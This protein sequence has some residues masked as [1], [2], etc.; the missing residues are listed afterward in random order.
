MTI[1]LGRAQNSDYAAMGP[2]CCPSTLVPQAI[3]Q[4]GVARCRRTSWS[5]KDLP[6]WFWMRPQR[7]RSP[8]Q[9]CRRPWWP[10]LS[11]WAIMHPS[12]QP[13]QHHASTPQWP[14][15]PPHTKVCVPLRPQPLMTL[16]QGFPC[17]LVAISTWLNLTLLKPC[18]A[19]ACTFVW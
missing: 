4:E 12:C 18:R 15:P 13:S 9:W 8:R 11:S 10:L 3:T 16:K 5:P 19:C 17:P 1:V 7:R 14:Q 2:R 6:W